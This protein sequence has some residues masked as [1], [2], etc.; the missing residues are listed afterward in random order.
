ML[1]VLASQWCVFKRRKEQKE[2]RG[3]EMEEWKVRDSRI[4]RE[5]EGEEG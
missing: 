2:D 4:E 1:S 3:K 5:M